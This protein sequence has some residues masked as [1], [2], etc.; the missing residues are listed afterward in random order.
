MHSTKIAFSGILTPL[1]LAALNFAVR[2]LL[3]KRG[4]AALLLLAGTISTACADWV[5]VEPDMASPGTNIRTA[6]PG[7]SLSIASVP[8]AE[9][10]AIDGYSRHNNTNVATTGSLVFGRSD[11]SQN[12]SQAWAESIGLL[13]ADFLFRADRVQVDLIFVDDD[14]GALWAYDAY[15]NLLSKATAAGDGRTAMSS[16]TITINRNNPDIAYVL[17]GGVGEDAI[18]LD[19]LQ[20]QFPGQPVVAPIANA[21]SDQLV[22][23]GQRVSLNATAS[24][25]PDGNYPLTFQ[26]TFVSRPTGSS[27]ILAGANSASAS[28][29]PDQGGS[30]VLKLIVNDAFALASSPDTTSIRTD[31]ALVVIEPDQFAEGASMNNPAAGVHLSIPTRPESAVQ[32]A[33]AYSSFND[34]NLA[35]TGTRVFAKVPASSPNAAR[36]WDEGLGLLR[37]DFDLPVDLV[38]ID[39]VF[40]DDDIGA[41]SAYDKGGNLLDRFTASGDGRGHVRFVTAEISRPQ[42]DIAYILAGGVGAEALLL[43]NLQARLYSTSVSGVAPV[44]SAGNDQIARV[45]LAVN[46][47]GSASN[48]PDHHFP[49]TYTWRFVSTPASSNSPLLDPNSVNP[50]FTPDKVG[51]YILELVVTDASGMSSLPDTISVTTANLPPIA[52]AGADQSV[53]QIGSLIQLDG[54][55][56]YDDDGHVPLTYD[57]SVVEKPAA[58]NATLS[59]S[60][61]PIPRFTAD[62]N[63]DYQF[64]LVVRDALLV[65][66]TPDTVRVSFNNLTPVCNAGG[67]QS[68]ALGATVTLDGSQTTD[69]N[70]DALAYQ[71]SLVSQP[72]GSTSGIAN[73]TQLFAQIT[74]DEPG[75]YVASFAASDGRVS[76]VP[77]HTT[78]QVIVTP[79]VTVDQAQSLINLINALHDSAFHNAN[80]R[81]ALTNKLQAVIQMIDD[82]D[83]QNAVDKLQSDILAKTDGCFASSAPDKNDKIVDCENQKRIDPAVRRLIKLVEE[84]LP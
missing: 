48:D 68:I 60:N 4:I 47:D 45:G 10:R 63:G 18:L 62:S 31:S 32:S 26:W 51:G 35:T 33:D 67:N 37:A 5:Y 82:D 69:A 41:L 1:F 49:L 58:S 43:D 23:I 52:D 12:P 42:S 53:V 61:S 30:Y 81:N 66:S 73:A 11:G 13:R 28:F 40:D 64:Q 59:N 44:A 78:I 19:N 54:S 9:V 21:G 24:V 50:T 16:R 55:A 79:G 56:S 29:I 8:N 14:I 34:R 39:L 3:E 17:I 65:T 36:S 74:P 83:Y 76:C 84:L 38:R 75:N 7:V 57:W 46:L 27:A 2:S 22:H 6:F 25:D 15:G 72:V 71:W 80:F 70:G 20:V 77:S